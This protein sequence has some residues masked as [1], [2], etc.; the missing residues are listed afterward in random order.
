MLFRSSL[1]AAALLLAFSIPG[2]E[3]ASA[4]VTSLAKLVEDRAA[5]K[6]RVGNMHFELENKS[7]RVRKRTALMVHAAEGAVERIAIF[8][9]KPSMIENT[10]FLSH[11]HSTKA[12]QNW[13][14]LPATDRVRRLPASERGDYFMGTDFT[15]GDL[16][17]NFKF[18]SEDWKFTEASR[19][20]IGGKSYPM[21]KGVAASGKK[22][23]EMG[24]SSFRALIDTNSA[25]PVWIEFADEDGDP[26]KRV[27]VYETRVIGGAHTAMR[28][29]VHNLQT[30]HT[31][32][33]HFTNMRYVPKLKRS[34]FEPAALSYG[35]P[36]VG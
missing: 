11:N 36:S 8:F 32:R 28:F 10:A 12:D 25:F 14:Y 26:L 18:Y 27:R 7:G 15:F 21:L 30:G 5:N 6:G 20:S 33:V 9:T 35:V 4:D 2:S 31:T 16:Q 3:A 22:A 34:V 23:R 24:Y 1:A 17:D 19:G 13:L 29:S